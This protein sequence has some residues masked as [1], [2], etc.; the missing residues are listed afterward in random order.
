MIQDD[1]KQYKPIPG[2]KSRFPKGVSGNIAGKPKGAISLK[3]KGWELLK[4]TITTELTDKFMQEMQQ[5]EG[6]A[7]INAYLNVLEFFRPRLSRTESLNQ[8]VNQD[9]VVISVTNTAV[10][11]MFPDNFTED[12]DHEDI[13]QG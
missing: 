8:N 10:M 12:T 11:S 6:T 13:Q 3:T 2:E 1:S 4:E 7:Y 9:Q 5:L